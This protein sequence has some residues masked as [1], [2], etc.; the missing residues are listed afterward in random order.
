[1]NDKIQKAPKK[2]RSSTRTKS[3]KSAIR[4]AAAVDDHT[5]CGCCGKLNNT[6]VDDKLD[7]DW[8]PCGGN[9]YFIWMHETCAQISGIGLIDDDDIFTCKSCL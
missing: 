4:M 8:Y 5:S 1:L 9:D 7:E 6:P 2:A 3:T